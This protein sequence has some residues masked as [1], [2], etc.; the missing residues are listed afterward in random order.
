LN[1]W[2]P[3]LTNTVDGDGV[4]SFTTNINYSLPQQFY[5]LSQ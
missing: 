2:I 4:F 1:Q 5:R 3:L